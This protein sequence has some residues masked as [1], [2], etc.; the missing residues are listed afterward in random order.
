MLRGAG[1]GKFAKVDF[2]RCNM[3]FSK[4]DFGKERLLCH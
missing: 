1:V 3:H 2:I 4:H